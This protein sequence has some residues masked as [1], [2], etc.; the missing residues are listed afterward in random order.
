[1]SKCTKCGDEVD[2]EEACYLDDDPSCEEPLCYDCYVKE[3]DE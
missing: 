1:M 3:N 2:I